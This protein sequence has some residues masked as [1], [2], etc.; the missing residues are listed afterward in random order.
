MSAEVRQLK[1]TDNERNSLITMLI[2]AEFLS[3]NLV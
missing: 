2:H 1:D 3:S